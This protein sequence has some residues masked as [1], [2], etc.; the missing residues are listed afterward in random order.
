[1]TAPLLGLEDSGSSSFLPRH[2]CA[3]TAVVALFVA[4]TSV[5]ALGM[6]PSI[7]SSSG[8]SRSEPLPALTSLVHLR[9]LENAV[10]DETG[11]DYAP[12]DDYPPVDYAPPDYASGELPAEGPVILPPPPDDI[13][14]AE[15]PEEAPIILPPPQDCS[16]SEEPAGDPIPPPS[17]AGYDTLPA[18]PTYTPIILPP[19]PQPPAP[20][21]SSPR[22]DGGEGDDD[23]PWYKNEWVWG[24]VGAIVGIVGVICCTY[25]ET[26]CCTKDGPRC[27]E[28]NHE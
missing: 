27:S 6:V 23:R 5:V 17:C 2:L 9:D 22:D 16:P 21:I 7:H 19:S 14:S 18:D 1:M 15:V 12:P 28:A 4:A 20:S 8:I 26:T 24:M 3:A 11:V 13:T 10:T 25:G